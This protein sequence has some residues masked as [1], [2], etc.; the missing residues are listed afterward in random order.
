[1]PKLINNSPRFV[2]VTGMSGSG[3]STCLRALE[4]L[5]FYCVDNLPSA[6]LPALHETLL[7]HLETAPV[8]V[9][10][11]IRAGSMLG[12]LDESWRTL[13]SVGVQPELL[14]LD[15]ADDI[16]IRRFSE[17]RRRHPVWQVGTI[18]DSIRTE[19]NTM[20]ALRERTTLVIDTTDSTVH[21]LKRQIGR[22]FD[23]QHSAEM[24]LVVSLMSFGF[25]HGVPRDADYV[26]D[27]RWLENPYF[28]PELKALTGHD[29]AVVEFVM[30]RG[31][32]QA[33]D[34]ISQLLDYTLPLHAQEGRALVTLAI[35]CTGGQHRSVALAEALA[36]H[37]RHTQIGRVT[38]THRDVLQAPALG[39]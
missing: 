16:L 26:I 31:G 18:S 8:A 25:K 36:D 14:F 39:S 34:R 5:G 17:T 15:C 35:G 10:I 30:Q 24:R 19:R 27:V 29:R 28:I 22:L 23:P 13:Q 6:L 21:Q 9:G 7:E 20:L 11:D 12:D 3:R 1:M 4:D 33:L 32:T 37:L 2:L 38:V